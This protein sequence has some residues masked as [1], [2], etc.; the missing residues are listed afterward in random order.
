MTVIT[1]TTDFGRDDYRAGLLKGVIWKIAPQVEIADLTHDISAHNILE[2]ALVLQDS[3][4]FFPVETIHVAVVDPGVGTDRRAIAAKIDTQYFVGPDNGIFSLVVKHAEVYGKL[5]NFFK[6]ENPNYW[7]PEISNVFHGRDIFS[8]VAAH[9]AEGTPLSALGTEI[10]DPVR[11]EIPEPFARRDGWV[12]QVIH[13]DHFGNLSTNLTRAHLPGSGTALV[14]VKG[15]QMIGI[16]STFG[17]RPP[18]TLVALIDSS[19]YLSICVVNGSA[20]QTLGV[21]PGEKVLLQA[22]C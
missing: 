15:R 8:P 18:G 3:V 16:V 19:G 4:P 13:I 5:I 14:E 6:L 2:A 11:I 12:G 21:N 10:F 22:V 17:D 9:L 1:L 20:S 7:L